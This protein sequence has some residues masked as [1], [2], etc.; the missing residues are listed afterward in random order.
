M[1]EFAGK[2]FTPLWLKRKERK[3]ILIL[4]INNLFSCEMFQGASFLPAHGV[5]DETIRYGFYA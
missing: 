3:L 4:L 5:I 2:S 1:I